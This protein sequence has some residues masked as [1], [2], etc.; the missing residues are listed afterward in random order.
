M[1]Y[2]SRE[3]CLFD[4][5]ISSGA[6]GGRACS[7]FVTTGGPRR[8]SINIVITGHVTRANWSNEALCPATRHLPLICQFASVCP[9]SDVFT[10]ISSWTVKQTRSY[11]LTIMVIRKLL[12]CT[13]LQQSNRV[14]HDCLTVPDWTVSCSISETPSWV[15]LSY[16]QKLSYYWAFRVKKSYSN[17]IGRP[18]CRYIWQRTPVRWWSRSTRGT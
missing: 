4:V 7:L 16:I 10:N 11:I 2:T 15:T 18:L 1:R 17:L 8:D 13:S 14:W 6:A 12:Q 9:R 3:Y 5:F